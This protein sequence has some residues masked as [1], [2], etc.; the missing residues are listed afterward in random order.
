MKRSAS[1]L[2][3]SSPICRG[4]T[5][6]KTVNADGR[7][8]GQVGVRQIPERKNGVPVRAERSLSRWHGVRNEV[9]PPFP[10]ARQTA[11]SDRL[12]RYL[13]PDGAGAAVWA[14]KGPTG[15]TKSSMV[16]PALLAVETT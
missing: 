14:T 5:R 13:L 6:V 16:P 4:G 7:F 15:V 1:P 11:S 9:G 10:I 3:A 2:R 8:G 12:S